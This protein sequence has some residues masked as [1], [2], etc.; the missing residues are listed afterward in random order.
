M[1]CCA[2]ALIAEAGISVG[3]LTYRIDSCGLEARGGQR[4]TR[5]R[6]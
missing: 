4:A 3:V 6:G 2:Q 1:R 5:H